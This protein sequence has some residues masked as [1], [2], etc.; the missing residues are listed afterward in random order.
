MVTLASLEEG[1]EGLGEIVL[2]PEEVEGRRGRRIGSALRLQFFLCL[3]PVFF[4]LV[5]PLPVFFVYISFGIF[6][7]KGKGEPHQGGTVACGLLRVALDGD[8]I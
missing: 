1:W 6:R 4:S 3:F 8:G 7:K 5:F 2:W